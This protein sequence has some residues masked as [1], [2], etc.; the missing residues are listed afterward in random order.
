MGEQEADA[1]IQRLIAWS[2]PQDAIRA[3][4]LTSTRAVPHAVVD[5]LSD[6]DIILVVRAIRPFVADRGW[7][8]DFGAVLVAYWDPI[9]PDRNFHIE[10]A[11]NVV[12]YADG[13]KIDFRLW[14][15][16]LLHTVTHEPSLPS[17]LDAGYRVLLDKDGLAAHLRPPTYRAYI[18]ERPSEEMY[19]TIIEEFF[20]DAPYV[21]KYLWRNELLP[22]KWCLD[23]DMKHVYLRRLLEWRVERDHGWA[24]PTRNLGKGLERRLPAG[25]QARLTGTYAGGG[26][27]ENWVAL[28]RTLALFRDVALDVAAD[29]GYTYPFDLDRRVT[30][31]VRAIQ[32]RER[33]VTP[34]G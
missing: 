29:L 14:P 20:N 26:I 18:P 10:Q 19:W 30:A 28:F 6:Y 8:E 12:Q 24:L 11:G 9:S 4:L 7:V 34:D 23:Y 33:G 5:D 32:G 13:L 2:D 25:L 17:E 27:A 21:A 16:A 15:V 3:I 1:I 22:A 31:Y